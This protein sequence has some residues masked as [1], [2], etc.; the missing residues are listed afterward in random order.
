MANVQLKA[1]KVSEV[2]FINKV[3]GK[4]QLKF[5]N[6]VTYNVRYSGTKFCEGTLTVEVFDKENPDTI[7]VKVTLMG[8]FDILNNI[9]REF[10]HVETFNELFPIV[11]AFVLTLSTNAGIPPIFLQNVN[12]ENQEIYRM[13]MGQPDLGR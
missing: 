6:K 5:S 7:S 8:A 4:Q 13:E 12:I 3:Q 2:N 1:F 10:L 11:K 9:E